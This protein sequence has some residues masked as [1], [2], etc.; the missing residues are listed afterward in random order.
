MTEK[1]IKI[2]RH[3]HLPLLSVGRINPIAEI[4]SGSTRELSVKITFKSCGSITTISEYSPVQK[5][6]LLPILFRPLFERLK[7]L[8]LN[9]K[10]TSNLV[11]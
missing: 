7:Q 11:S 3:E 2:Q 8:E 1:T 10:K 5:R 9:F 6:K 4:Q